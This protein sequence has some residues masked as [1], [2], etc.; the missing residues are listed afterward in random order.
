M[1]AGL[2]MRRRILLVVPVDRLDRAADEQRVFG[3]EAELGRIVHQQ[4]AVTLHGDDGAVRPLANAGP[5]R[6]LALDR[7]RSGLD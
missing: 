2:Q 6:V 7:T 5:V 1:L 4:L 3:G